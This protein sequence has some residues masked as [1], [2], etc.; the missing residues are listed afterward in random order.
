MNVIPAIDLMDGRCV[1]LLRGNFDQQTGYRDDP[2]SL[3]RDYEA[4]G[5]EQLHIVDLD[6]ARSGRQQNAAVVREIVG[7]SGLSAQ[8]GGGIRDESELEAWLNAGIDRVVI[9]SLAVVQAARIRDWLASYGSSRIVLALDVTFDQGHVPRIATHGWSRA[10]ETTLWQCLDD[11]A[12]TGLKHVLC[13]DTG[14]DGA[15]TGPNLD[16]YAQ[17]LERYPDIL[18]QASGGVR[19]VDDLR[20]LEQIGVPAAITGRALL[21]GRITA[22]ELRSFL[23]AA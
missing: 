20:E 16:L 11:Y 19:N 22:G 2:V 23:P 3:A 6:G 8:L 13:T 17:L 21:D 18:V 4:M 10:S 1:R 7:T 15:L 12:G 14:R 9:G 5:F